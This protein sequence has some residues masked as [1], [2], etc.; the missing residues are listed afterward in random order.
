MNDNKEAI[1]NIS[2]SFNTLLEKISD[3][4]SCLTQLAKA[5][6]QI[7]ESMGRMALNDGNDLNGNWAKLKELKQESEKIDE[8]IRFLS[9][10][11]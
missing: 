3:R 1:N 6:L 9:Q 11:T 5:K 7:V 10:N 8:L 4:N 2:N